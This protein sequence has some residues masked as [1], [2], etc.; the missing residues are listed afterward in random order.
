[1]A[2]PRTILLAARP[3][4][5]ERQAVVLTLAL[6][7]QVQENRAEDIREVCPAQVE[8]AQAAD[9]QEAVRRAEV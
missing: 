6:G 7:I 2:L 5:G 4:V 8:A 1:M 3:L 9:S